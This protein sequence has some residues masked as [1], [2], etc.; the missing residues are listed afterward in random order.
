[1]GVFSIFA[2]LIAYA[3]KPLREISFEKQLSSS[4]KNEWKKKRVYWENK[5]R[6][7]FSDET[8]AQTLC[9]K[10]W[11]NCAEKWLAYRKW[12]LMESAGS[13][14]LRRKFSINKTEASFSIFAFKFSEKKL[15]FQRVHRPK[16]QKL[17]VY[18]CVYKIVGKFVGN[19]WAFFSEEF[20]L[21]TA[22]KQNKAKITK[23]TKK[24]VKLLFSGSFESCAIFDEEFLGE[25]FL[26]DEEFPGTEFEE[27]KED[28]EFEEKFE[29]EESVAG[30]I[31]VIVFVEGALL[32]VMDGD[33]TG[34][35]SI[36]EAGRT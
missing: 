30:V 25:E 6:R 26:E 33:P 31:V 27:K 9:C 36:I 24:V 5:F 3:Y 11:N 20:Y 15:T 22:I 35:P 19:S 28:E 1:M 16:E 32:K 7:F 4:K 8:E 2:S 23:K 17:G 34:R 12:K 14:Y 10:L 29:E 21:E 18:F 13:A